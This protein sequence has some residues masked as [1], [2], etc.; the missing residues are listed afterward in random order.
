MCW[1]GLLCFRGGFGCTAHSLYPKKSV[2]MLLQYGGVTFRAV[3]EGVRMVYSFPI[4]CRYL[5]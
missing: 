2:S 5:R 4:S 3:N 1:E